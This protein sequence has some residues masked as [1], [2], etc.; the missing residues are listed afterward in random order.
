ME[1]FLVADCN[2][3]AV[4]WIDR[5]PDWPGPALV[6]YGPAG[7]GKTH[8][9]RVWQGLSGAVAVTPEGLCGSEPRELLGE[10]RGGV[11]EDVDRALSGA[12]ERALLHL[13]NVL[14]ERRGHLLVT[15]ERPPA[16]LDLAVPDLA[17]RL[18]AAPAAAIGAP[19]DAL[20][21]AVLIK[22]FADRQLAVAHDVIA[23]LL[24]RME[25]SFEAAGRVVAAID[26]TALAGRRGISVALVRQ[27]LADE[28]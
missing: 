11:V 8:L 22:L 24:A 6:V 26:R 18:A 9:A 13:Y 7:C 19:D 5:W 12:G 4:A 14:A 27:V 28:A 15:A 25:R 3:E 2:R 20:L 23:Y 17:S 1:D 10:A 21:A 16:S